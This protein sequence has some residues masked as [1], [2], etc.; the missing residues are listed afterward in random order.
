MGCA[1]FE[2]KEWLELMSRHGGFRDWCYSN[3]TI[4]EQ[5]KRSCSKAMRWLR[6]GDNYCGLANR[7]T[8][9]DCWASGAWRAQ[10]YVRR[11]G[12]ECV[13]SCQ[14]PKCIRLI[15]S[16]VSPK[17]SVLHVIVVDYIKI[18]CLSH[19]FPFSRNNYALWPEHGV[20]SAG[21]L[22][23]RQSFQTILKY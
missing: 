17:R 3:R 15:F 13:S 6:S 5:T 4:A 14:M 18:T 12:R 11:I 1:D 16:H 9:S 2:K 10:H 19:I 22:Q 23:L 8:L 21:S 20:V 7:C